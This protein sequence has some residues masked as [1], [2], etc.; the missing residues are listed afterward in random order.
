MTVLR[1]KTASGVEQRSFSFGTYLGV[2]LLA[3]ALGVGAVWAAAR[4]TTTSDATTGLSPVEIA[5]IRAD[6]YVNQL[7]TQWLTQVQSARADALA[8]QLSA[9]SAYRVADIQAQRAQAMVDH[10]ANQFGLS[11]SQ[12]GELRAEAMVVHF[13]NQFGLSPA[14][15]SSARAEE[16]VSHFAAGYQ[17]TLGEI[18]E[19]RAQAMVD[20]HWGGNS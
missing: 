12:I 18:S 2:G 19:Q 16:M 5:E 3:I 14:E 8:S 11:P 13:A 1:G 7:H 20:N 15:I 17:P 10:F 4:I 6:A 9:A